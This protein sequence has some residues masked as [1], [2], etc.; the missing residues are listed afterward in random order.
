MQHFDRVLLA[1]LLGGV[2]EQPAGRLLV[3]LGL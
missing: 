2:V 1:D 3:V